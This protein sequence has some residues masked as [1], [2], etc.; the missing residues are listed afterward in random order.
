MKEN[1][2]DRSLI[3]WGVATRA[4]G[5]Q[6]ESGDQ[7]LVESFSNG[8]LVAVVDGLGHG[9]NA[10]KA[11]RT[12]IAALEDHAHE[13]VVRLLRRCHKELRGAR[14]VVMSL[15]S[16]NVLEGTMTWLGVG[17]VKGVFLYADAE[18][19]P[20]RE[21]LLPR[22]GVVGY[23]LPS[24]RAAVIPVSPGD[25]LV[26]ATDGLRSSFADGLTLNNS[27][28]R[29]ADRLLAQYGRQTDDAL[30]M[31]ARYVGRET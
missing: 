31:V 24:L 27:P 26:F 29:I 2:N 25:T 20:A 19:D 15:A 18:A 10:A 12:A 6:S 14:G 4:L 7:Y 28:Q 17:N 8:V 23:Q 5:G 3:Q 9:H 16:F 22:G 21:R 13:S 30:V 11:A 1:T